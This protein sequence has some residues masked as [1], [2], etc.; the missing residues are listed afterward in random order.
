MDVGEVSPRDDRRSTMADVPEE[1][2]DRLLAGELPA[3]EQRRIAQAAL[4]DP[5]LFEQ[6][7]AAGVVTNPSTRKF[8]RREKRDG[9]IPR[10]EQFQRRSP[11]RRG[12][13]RECS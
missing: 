2:I 10:P 1:T 12:P 5:D 7:T 9:A 6:L 11:A 4:S 3:A 13:A 8:C